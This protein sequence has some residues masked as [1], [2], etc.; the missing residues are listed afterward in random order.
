MMAFPLKKLASL[1]PS[2]W[3]DLMAASIELAIARVRLGTQDTKDLLIS[4]AASDVPQQASLLSGKQ[5]RL[6]ERVTFAVPAVGPRLP[7]RADCLV[8]AMAA[9]RWLR[10]NEIA[11]SIYLGVRKGPTAGFEAHAWLMLGDKIITGGEDKMYTT[12]VSP[13]SLVTER[14][15]SS[16]TSRPRASRP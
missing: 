2:G 7:W 4:P 3:M 12:F 6:V 14:G 13:D 1:G 10:R 5:R 9:R 8:Q 16:P 11:T 15:L